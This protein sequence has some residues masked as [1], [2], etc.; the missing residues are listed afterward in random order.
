MK[1]LPRIFFARDD[2]A[3]PGQQE[4]QDLKRLLLEADPIVTPAQLARR[5]VQHN[6]RATY[7]S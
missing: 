5:L 3:G 2:C 1:A 4:P 6:R 7:P